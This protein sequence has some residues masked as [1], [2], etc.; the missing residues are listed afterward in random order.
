MPVFPA[1]TQLTIYIK[2]SSN[3]YTK[4][5]PPKAQAPHTW[6]FSSLQAPPLLPSAI[7][8]PHLP[9]LLPP[10]VPTVTQKT[11]SLLSRANPASNV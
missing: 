4:P 2:M 10:A 9:P 11:P 6:L 7:L 1:L 8:L 5:V 3:T